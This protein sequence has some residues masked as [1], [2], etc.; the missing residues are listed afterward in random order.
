[1]FFALWPDER[2][3]AGLEALVQGLPEHRGRLVH[4]EDRHITLAFLGE[5]S[6]EFRACAE[7]A[8]Q[9]VSAPPCELFIDQV[10]Y[11]PRP[12]ILWCGATQVPEALLALVRTLQQELKECGFQP[13]ARPYAPHV[14][15]ARKARKV[16]GYLLPENLSWPV[17][18]F[19][20]V[21]SNMDGPPPRY[22]VLRRWPLG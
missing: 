14:T 20:L 6:A 4:R 1:L 3:R 10:G 13:E 22:Q 18:E 19:V 9:R 8:A 11:W 12:R 21:T 15:L 2:V 16:P 5:V 7:E 17:R